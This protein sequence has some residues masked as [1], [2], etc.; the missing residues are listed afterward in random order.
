MVF[1]KNDELYIVGKSLFFKSLVGIIIFFV[2]DFLTKDII[3]SCV[4][5]NINSFLFVFL[6]DIKNLKVFE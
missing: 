1:T 5:L 4:A 6:Y 3:V 2:I